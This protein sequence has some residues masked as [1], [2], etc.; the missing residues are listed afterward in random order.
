MAATRARVAYLSVW[1]ARVLR[2]KDMANSVSGIKPWVSR[3]FSSVPTI[4]EK[5]TMIGISKNRRPVARGL[6]VLAAVF[7][8]FGLAGCTVDT[9]QDN[10]APAH[11]VAPQAPAA[12]VDSGAG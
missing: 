3:P 4:R 1:C 6:V 10:A 7:G 5:T 2:E 9:W 8:A 11:G 12:A